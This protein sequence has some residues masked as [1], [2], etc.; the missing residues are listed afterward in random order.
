MA[1]Y[2]P[3]AYSIRV[4]GVVYL[5]Q[6]IPEPPADKRI[7]PHFLYVQSTTGAG[8][9][10][11]FI[12]GKCFVIES[13]E[14]VLNGGRKATIKPVEEED[15][16][17]RILHLDSVR[18]NEAAGVEMT[19]DSVVIENSSG[20]LLKGDKPLNEWKPGDLVCEE[21]FPEDIDK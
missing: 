17:M 16:R 10:Y 8:G 15:G 3:L 11:D 20:Y 18:E 4:W 6:G 5:V 7:A 19:K 14:D 1:I 21:L 9:P 2:A 13:I 12:M